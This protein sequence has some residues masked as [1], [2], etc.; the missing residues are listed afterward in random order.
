MWHGERAI[1]NFS[2]RDKMYGRDTEIT[3][4]KGKFFFSNSNRS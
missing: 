4:K 2:S 3:E 1:S